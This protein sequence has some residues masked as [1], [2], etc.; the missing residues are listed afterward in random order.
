MSDAGGGR[1]LARLVALGSLLLLCSC[2]LTQQEL[3]DA[4]DDLVDVPADDT[5]PPDV[6]DTDRTGGLEPDVVPPKDTES[7]TGDTALLPEPGPEPADLTC[8]EL[9]IGS[10][11]GAAAWAGNTKG[12]G[13]NYDPTCS[14]TSEGGRDVSLAW[15]APTSGCFELTTQPTTGTPESFN[16]T[17][18]YAYS[19]CDGEV[20]ACNDDIVSSG[21]AQNLFSQMRL[22]AQS[23]GEGFLLVVDG[24]NETDFG[25]M[26]LSIEETTGPG[27]T[28]S[29][30]SA[31]GEVYAGG[32]TGA[33]VAVP[34]SCD[35]TGVVVGERWFSWIAPLAGTYRFRAASSDGAF[36]VSVHRPCETDWLV[37][38]PAQADV[39]LLA[40]ERVEIRVAEAASS[41]GSR[42][43][44]VTLWVEALP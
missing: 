35:T 26:S 42:A 10:N 24:F 14:A 29:L 21:S 39:T 40:K 27:L 3:D 8:A 22:R 11:V 1:T 41:S 28:A 38:G 18:L 16:D 36:D 43:S 34:E 30:G 23:A 20:L 37:C 33:D 2:W 17:V 13:D 19:A 4:Y 6:G 25:V 44:D 5:T 9:D 15:V 7:D 31:L 12:Y 32:P